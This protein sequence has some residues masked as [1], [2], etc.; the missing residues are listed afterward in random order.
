MNNFQNLNKI[1]IKTIKINPEYYNLVYPLSKPEYEQL[2][3]SIRTSGLHLPIVI[4]PKGEI[5]D[6][7]NRH[8]ICQEFQLP[9]K[10]EIKSFDSLI[11]EK[12]FVI[13]INLKRRHLNDFQ[14]AELAY[15]LEAFEK[16]KAKQRQSEAGKL[17]GKGKKEDNNRLVRSND[18]K[19]L[20]EKG[21]V[22]EAVSKE[23]GISAK[24]YQRAKTIIENG[25][26]EIKNSLRK[27]KTSISKEYEKIQRDK[28]RQELFSQINLLDNN[29]SNEKVENKNTITNCK[30]LHGDFTLTLIQKEVQDNSVDLILTDPPYSQDSLILYQEL[31]KFATRVLK[32]G[33]SIVTFV[34]HIILNEV[35]KAF[36]KY[37]LNSDS[38]CL[39]Y[40]W[41]LGV[42]HSGHHAKIYPRHVFAQWKPMLWYIKGEK[43]NDLTISN[44]FGDL[45]ESNQPTKALHEWEQ[46]TVEAEYIIKNLTI[47]NQI[48]LDPM[49][50]IGTTAIAASKLKRKFIGIEK[51]ED[52]FNIANARISNFVHGYNTK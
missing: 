14:K 49:M 13:D 51:D 27:G 10:Y 31:S 42:K 32:P 20:K 9:L 43:V 41:I 24:T 48:I 30:L 16:E 23:L 22:I 3:D 34:G 52:T 38:C 21:R 5:L 29:S 46:S 40:W 7:H 37:S 6:G 33:G 1:I 17:F 28:K 11:D 39:K 44:T 35:I 12:R 26:E 19:L 36:E 50:G 47:E 25:P 4:N 18:H 15:K 45:I 2:K 8:K